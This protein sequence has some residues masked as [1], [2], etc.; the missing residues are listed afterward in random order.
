M[1][2]PGVG[3]DLGPDALG[4]LS[5]PRRSFAWTSRHGRAVAAGRLRPRPGASCSTSRRGARVAQAHVSTGEGLGDLDRRSD[6]SGASGCAS[7]ARSASPTFSRATTRCASARPVAVAGRPDGPQRPRPRSCGCARAARTTCR[8]PST[9]STI[10]TARS[11]GLHPGD[12]GYAGGG[13]GARPIRRRAGGT[14]IDG[15]GYGSYERDRRCSHV[16]AG[17]L[18]AMQLTND[19]HG[20]HL[21]AHFAQASEDQSAARR[22]GHLP[23][24]RPQHTWGWEDTFSGGGDRDCNDMVVQLDFCQRRRRAAGS[25]PGLGALR[26]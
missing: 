8:S 5:T 19:T 1:T 10:S 14:S 20:Q 26:G 15:P 7:A 2:A 18:V 4:F 13:A 9:G 16:N 23:E 21:L 6:G 24:L 3:V 11:D 25:R 12:A 22:V 17:D